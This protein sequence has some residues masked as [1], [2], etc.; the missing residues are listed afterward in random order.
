MVPA[1][2]PQSPPDNISPHISIYIFIY[3]YILTYIC[4]Y[5]YTF[6]QTCL[7][8]PI[9]IGTYILQPTHPTG[10][11]GETEIPCIIIIFQ[12]GNIPNPRDHFHPKEGKGVI[13]LYHI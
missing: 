2:S 9:Y 1:G 5:I 13:S 12:G 11:S 8:L 7:Y 6:V 10:S 3:I 4:T